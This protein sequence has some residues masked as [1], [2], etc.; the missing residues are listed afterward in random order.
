MRNSNEP[1]SPELGELEEIVMNIVWR[2]APCT[3]EACREA[4]LPERPLKDSTIRTV[5]RRLEEKGFV[6]HTTSGRTFLYSPAAAPQNVA[7]KAVKQIVERFCGGSVERLLLGMV[8]NEVVG[9]AELERLARKIAA[10]KGGRK[11]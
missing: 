5:L 10:A 1:Q 3:A 4:L 8:D 9:K 6:K 7:A 2:D 11:R